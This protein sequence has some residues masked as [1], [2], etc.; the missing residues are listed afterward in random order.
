MPCRPQIVQEMV[1]PTQRHTIQRFGSL[2]SVEKGMHGKL[3]IRA[4]GLLQINAVLP[5][6][7]TRAVSSALSAPDGPGKGV[8]HPKTYN[9]TFWQLVLS[10]ARP[11]LETKHP[12]GRHSANHSSFATE[13]DQGG[14]QCPV[15]PRWCRKWCGPPKDIPYSVLAACT[16]LK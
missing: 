11:A 3:T 13:S 9:T 16:R 2:Y 1:W 5:Q 12:Y 8:A 7:Q 14:H 6:S 4:T 15:G 10:G